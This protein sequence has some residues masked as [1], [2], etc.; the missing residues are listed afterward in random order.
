MSLIEGVAQNGTFPVAPAV[1]QAGRGVQ[2]PTTPAPEYMAPQYQDPAAPRVRVIQPV[3]AAQ[4]SDRPAMSSKALL[5]L[6]KFT[7]LFPVHL[8]GV[9]SEDPQDYLDRFHKVLR[10]M[11]IVETNGVDFA[12]F[13]M[14]GSAKRW[15]IDYMLTRPAGLPALTWDQFSQLF[16]EKYLPVTLREDYRRQFECLLQGNMIVT[17]YETRFADLA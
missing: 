3:V 13:R 11:G 1:S 17:Q 9:P 10:N 6:N 16:L 14:T 2:T 8:S 7:K 5:R 15:W 12:A 4:A